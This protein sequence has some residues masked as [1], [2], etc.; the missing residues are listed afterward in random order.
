MKSGFMWYPRG[1]EWEWNKKKKGKRQEENCKTNKSCFFSKKKDEGK[2]SKLNERYVKFSSREKRST[3][4]EKLVF[5]KGSSNHYSGGSL[6]NDLIYR[7]NKYWN[8]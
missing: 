6:N 2:K 1:L 7:M 8:R 3:G 4:W 5:Q